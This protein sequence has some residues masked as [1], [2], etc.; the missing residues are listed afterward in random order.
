MAEETREEQITRL[1]TDKSAI[2]AEIR[3]QRT[4]KEVEEGGAGAKFRTVYDNQ[5]LSKLLEEINI[6]LR[7]LYSARGL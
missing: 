4:I 3:A 5:N 7:V 2:E 1:E 6:K